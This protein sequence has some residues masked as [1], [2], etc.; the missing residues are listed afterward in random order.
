[1]NWVEQLRLLLCRMYEE[2]GGN[3]KE[4]GITPTDWIQTLTTT[5]AAEG[6]P[7]FE[8]EAQWA[9]FQVLLSEVEVHLAQPGNTLSAA[10]NSALLNLIAAL[11]QDPAPGL[12]GK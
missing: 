8:T 11:R 10:D 9:D 5:Y 4:L 7:K 6:P 3:C 12:K 1:M 2:W